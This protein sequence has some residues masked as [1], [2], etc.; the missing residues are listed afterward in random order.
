M[1]H[2]LLIAEK[3]KEVAVKSAVNNL[4]LAEAIKTEWNIVIDVVL[5]GQTEFKIT[6]DGLRSEALS[7]APKEW[8]EYAL[9]AQSIF[10][11]YKKAC[12]TGNP[13]K[14]RKTLIENENRFH[15]AKVGIETIL[16]SRR[17]TDYNF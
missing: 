11:D 14:V 15:Q 10:A 7:L 1:G 4:E 5:K 8:Y 13:H 6:I 16:A 3:G 2:I 17:T 12:Y 9:L